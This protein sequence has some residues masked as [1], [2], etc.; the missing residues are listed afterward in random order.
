M[1][2]KTGEIKS[3]YKAKTV[4]SVILTSHFFHVLQQILNKNCCKR[5]RRWQIRKER[6]C[7]D[8]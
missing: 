4:V 7:D 8:L 1:S 6:I 5:C 3:D 2:H